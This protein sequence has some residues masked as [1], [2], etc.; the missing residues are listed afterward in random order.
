MSQPDHIGARDVAAILHLSVPTVKRRAKAG[1]IP[2]ILKAPGQ[3]GAYVFD[4]KVI[5]A[6]AA[7][8][9]AA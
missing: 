3:T 1:E 9:G 5:E 7:E 6:L 8:Q 2:S 4:R